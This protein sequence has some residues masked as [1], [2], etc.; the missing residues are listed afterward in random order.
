MSRKS[1]DCDDLVALFCALLEN[2]GIATAYVDVPGH[3]FMAFDSQ[4]SADEIGSSGLSIDD[5]IVVK[6]KVWIPIE[7]T[8]LGKFEFMRAWRNGA[9]R[10]YKELKEG[11]YPEIV[12]LGNA[13][14]VYTPSAFVPEGFIPII[15]N[16]ANII[17]TFQSELNALMTKVNETS[18]RE[19]ENR[20]QTEVNNVFVKNRYAMLLAKLGHLGKAEEV[21]L[22]ALERS[23]E[24]ASVLNNMANINMR[25]SNYETA[26]SFYNDATKADSS[27]G[28]VF[29]NLCKAQLKVGDKNA[30]SESY[31][32]AMNLNPELK[33]LYPQILIQLK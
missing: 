30:A 13:R 24:N 22:E 29:I 20:Y 17:S 31:T 3:V 26:I 28:Q 6:D 19:L 27:D 7:T 25:K 14:Q 5:V 23:P 2:S 9:R 32:E 21:L 10:Y 4:I 12:P 15:N 8:M 18:I 33:D 16:D 11:N 1:G